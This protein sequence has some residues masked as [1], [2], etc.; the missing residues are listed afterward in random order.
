MSLRRFYASVDDHNVPSHS[1]V[2]SLFSWRSLAAPTSS[3]LH[4]AINLRPPS[5]TV[6]THTSASNAVASQ[7]HDMPNACMSLCTQSVHSFSS[8]PHPLRTAP[9]RF[10]NMIHF[11]NRPPLIRISAPPL[12]TKVFS[13]ATSSQC[14]HIRL[15]QG[16]GCTR[17]YD[18]LVS[19][20]VPR[21]F[22]ARPGGIR[23]RV[24][25][26][27]PGGGSTYCIHTRGPR[28]PRPLP[29]GS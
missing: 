11:G 8:P 23:C 9:R 4:A 26:S 13:C 14:S 10:P 27:V 21:S 3:F 2:A 17:S 25:R 12:P 5:V 20:A 16:H 18:G 24:W 15:S 22:K 28:L 19:C 6:S 29:F 1:I 7:F